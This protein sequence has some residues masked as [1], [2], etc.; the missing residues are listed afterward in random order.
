ML[1]SS[2]HP[3]LPC[4]ALPCPALP[5]P[6]LLGPALW[7]VWSGLPLR[8]A[9]LTGNLSRR[10]CRATTVGSAPWVMTTVRGRTPLALPNRAICSRGGAAGQAE[11]G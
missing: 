5:C 3:Q 6:A 7:L 11:E 1:L 4:P 8:C 10:P 9:V 2:A